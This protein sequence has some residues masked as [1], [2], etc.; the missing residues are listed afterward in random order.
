MVWVNVDVDQSLEPTGLRT[1]L[2]HQ[3]VSPSSPIQMAS[4]AS[5]PWAL[6]TTQ[7]RRGAPGLPRP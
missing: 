2:H 1:Q 7:L 3:E 4:G 6:N 5:N